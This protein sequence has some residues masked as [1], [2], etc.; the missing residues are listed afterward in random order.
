MDNFSWVPFYEELAKTL[1]SYRSQQEELISFL[2]TLS[3]KK[4][5]TISLNDKDENGKIISLSEI[6]PFTFFANFNRGIKDQSRQEI[7]KII[8]DRFQFAAFFNQ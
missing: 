7:C 2:N 6:D 8:K 4:F 3:E 5:K 1:C